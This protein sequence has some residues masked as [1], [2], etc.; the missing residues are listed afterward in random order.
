[1]TFTIREL[2]D[3]GYSS[4]QIKGILGYIADEYAKDR[5]GLQEKE[6]EKERGETK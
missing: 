1:M 2:K 5:P 4:D 6:T 3:Q